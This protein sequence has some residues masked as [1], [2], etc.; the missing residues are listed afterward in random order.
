MAHQSCWGPTRTKAGVP[1]RSALVPRAIDL[2]VTALRQLHG[3][4][5]AVQLQESSDELG[6]GFHVTGPDG[7]REEGWVI[8]T[9]TGHPAAATRPYLSHPR[10]LPP[11]TH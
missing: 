10:Y 6:D 8:V 1:W 9:G 3:T 5:K 4:F 11:V 7:H 2:T